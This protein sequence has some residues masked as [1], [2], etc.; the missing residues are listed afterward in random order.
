MKAQGC[1]YICIYIYAEPAHNEGT[2]LYS[3]AAY[4]SGASPP[5]T[6]HNH[7]IPSQKASS[8][9]WPVG[10][11]KRK[12]FD[13]PVTSCN[14]C[15]ACHPDGRIACNCT[16]T[17]GGNMAGSMVGVDPPRYPCLPCGLQCFVSD[18]V[19]YSAATHTNYYLLLNP[20]APT[21]QA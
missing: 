14:I 20:A 10:P 16:R 21:S 7:S 8:C 6:A 18:A 5:C 11:P 13:L 3:T 4:G 12:D 15:H 9:D 2:R 17:P 19:A 1:V